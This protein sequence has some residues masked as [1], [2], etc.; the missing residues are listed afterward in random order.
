MNR[1]ALGRLE[2]PARG[3]EE[4]D[5]LERPLRRLAG[6]LALVESVHG[7]LGRLYRLAYQ[8]IAVVVLAAVGQQHQAVPGTGLLELRE[9]GRQRKAVDA[10]IEL[11]GV[12]ETDQQDPRRGALRRVVQHLRLA[13]VGGEVL[14][15]ED[16]LD[17]P[18]DRLVQC[19]GE[20][21]QVAVLEYADD[22]AGGLQAL[23]VTGLAAVF[24]G[25][26]RSV[27][28]GRDRLPPPFGWRYGSPQS[29]GRV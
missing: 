25:T 14:V 26:S 23:C 11:P 18:A 15:F 28:E 10:R 27:V 3:G 7:G 13:A 5:T 4:T 9:R 22:Q 29:M 8:A 2:L 6:A 12:A 16:R 21:C 20:R 17:A 19:L 24:H 1:R